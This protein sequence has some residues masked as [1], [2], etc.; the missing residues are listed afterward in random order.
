[1]DIP[2]EIVFHNMPNSATLEVEIRDRTDKLERRFQH[3]IGCRVSVE[4]LHRRHQSGN[5]YEVHIEMRV[6]GDDLVVSHEPHHA[7]DRFTD[8]NAGIAL[9][10]AFKA[11]E[12][13]LI[14]YKQRLRGDVK[15]HDDDGGMAESEMHEA[16]EH[17]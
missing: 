16:E 15:S 8:P 13:R 1:M 4:Q 17:R 3:L 12:R 7:H 5:I 11:A 6:P 14:D 9:R 2:V 10:N